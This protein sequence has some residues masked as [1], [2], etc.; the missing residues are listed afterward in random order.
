MEAIS[1][2]CHFTMLRPS[3]NCQTFGYCDL[4]D[5]IQF[6]LVSDKMI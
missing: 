1:M 2:L 5:G 3:A 6:P 4:T